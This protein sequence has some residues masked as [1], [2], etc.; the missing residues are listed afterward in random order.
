MAKE[1]EGF[2]SGFLKK[3][4]LP[5]FSNY[6]KRVLDSEI[7]GFKQAIERKIDFKMKKMHL[8]MMMYAGATILMVGFAMFIENLVSFPR[9]SGFIIVGAIVLLAAFIIRS[10][11]RE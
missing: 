4:L 5:L 7:K 8:T 2:F 3:D 6:V 9:G 10:L 1:K 11:I